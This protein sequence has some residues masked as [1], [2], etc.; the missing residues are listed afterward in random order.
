MKY[1]S[2]EDATIQRKGG[3]VLLL[4]EEGYRV[5]GFPKGTKDETVFRALDFANEAFEQGCEEGRREKQRELKIVL[6]IGG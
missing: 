3:L 4:N 5:F 2:R 6:G 1:L